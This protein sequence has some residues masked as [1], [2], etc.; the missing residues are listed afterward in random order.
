LSANDELVKALMA[1]EV[2][3]K[4]IDDDSDSDAEY[5]AAK[6]R[7]LSGARNTEEA[8]SGL[9]L[10][11]AV[12]A[13]PA[14]PARPTSLAMPPPIPNAAS[15]IGKQRIQHESE[16]SDGPDEDEDDPFADHNAVKTPYIEK[17]GL[18]W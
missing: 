3:D 1:Y 7:R 8:F 5:E 9:S 10:N 17:D 14:K 15:A 18:T 2:M 13:P 16:E 11:E 12:S 6:A 4:S